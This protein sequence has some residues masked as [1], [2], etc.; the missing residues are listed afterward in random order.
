MKCADHQLR[1]S[2]LA[3]LWFCAAGFAHAQ[4]PEEMR[5]KGG[6]SVEDCLLPAAAT[7]GTPNYPERALAENHSAK[8]QARLVFKDPDAAPQVQVTSD[9]K[10]EEFEQEVRKYLR[11]YRMPCLKKGQAPLTA[12]QEFVFSSSDRRVA[13]KQNIAGTYL[14]AHRECL[15]MVPPEFPGSAASRMTQGTVI[16]DITF[17]QREQAPKVRVVYGGGNRWLEES[18]VGAAQ[19]YRY[20]CD[21]PFAE[22]LT[23]RQQ[24]K[25]TIEDHERVRLKDTDLRG[26]LAIAE[27]ASWATA[28]FDTRTMGCPFDLRVVAFQPF[29][30]NGVD[31]FGTENPDRKP[32]IAWVEDMVLKVPKQLQPLLTG[33]SFV[34]HVPCVNFDLTG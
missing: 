4:A 2:A 1:R 10:D 25:F 20:Q 14:L 31:E 9:S 21:I 13:V 26:L 3:L 34:V 19:A 7:R 8:V 32:F 22:G 5:F 30:K 28:K 17:M 15:R 16:L 12:Q 23:G 27:K 29:D 11:Q 24:F 33:N 6:G 18:A